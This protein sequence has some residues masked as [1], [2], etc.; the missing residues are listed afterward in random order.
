MNITMKNKLKIL[1]LLEK[2][3]Y[4]KINDLYNKNK[5]FTEPKEILIKRGRKKVFIN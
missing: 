2:K 4:L 3:Q 5:N 1:K